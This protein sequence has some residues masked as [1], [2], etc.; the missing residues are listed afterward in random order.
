MQHNYYEMG[1]IAMNSNKHLRMEDINIYSCCGQATH[2]RGTQQYWLFKN[3]NI[4]P[5]KGKSRRPISATADH[6]MIETSAGYF[7][8]IDCDMGFGADDCINMHD[9][10]LFTTKASANSVRTKSAR[11]SYLYNKGEIFE[12]REDDYSPTGFTAKV[13]DVKVVDKENGVNEIFF[14]KEIPNPQNSGFILFNWRYNTSNIIVRNCYFHQN[15][16]RG[17]LII[18]RDVTIENCRFYRNEMGAIK[19]ETGYT[20]KSRSEGLGVNN[21]VVR[22]CSFD[23]CNPL[24]VRN[25]N[26]ERDIFMGVYMRTDPSPIR[27]NFPIIENVLFENNKF[28][29]TFGLVAFISSCH[30]VTFLNNT[31][32][33]TKERKTP[34]PYR[35]S[36]YLSH[37]N[38]VKIINNKFMLSD[39]APNPGI[40]T[41]KDSVKNTVVAGNEIVEKK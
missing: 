30:N 18:A 27:T 23:T 15:R 37:T 8:M 34:R 3:V 13:A 32:E 4:A 36:F 21:V 10:S 28:K 14:D 17:I 29:D 38:N 2:V 11:N 39:F 22:N 24:G 9:N 20:F 6:C 35:G 7:K 40:F 33:N 16:A 26:F 19:I 12:F 1:G 31:F 41:D 25:E 5:P